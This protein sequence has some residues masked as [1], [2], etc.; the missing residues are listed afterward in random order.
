MRGRLIYLLYIIST[1][2]VAR[3]GKDVIS[4]AER[5]IEAMALRMK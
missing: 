1:R 2:V 4:E 3:T 5:N